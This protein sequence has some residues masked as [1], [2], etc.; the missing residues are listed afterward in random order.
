M[1]LGAEWGEMPGGIVEADAAEVRDAIVLEV[2]DLMTDSADGV[3]LLLSAV[4]MEVAQR[5]EDRGAS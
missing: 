1:E 5:G 4:A 3:L 2:T